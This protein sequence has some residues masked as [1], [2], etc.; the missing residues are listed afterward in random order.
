MKKR[1]L[2][3]LM[4]GPFFFALSVNGQNFVDV[5]KTSN[6]QTINLATDQVLQVNLPRKAATGY[7]WC[8]SNTSDDKIISRS[9]EQIGESDFNVEAASGTL[10][11]KVMLGQSGTQIIRYTGNSQGTTELTLELKRPWEKDNPAIDYFTITIVSSGKYTGTYTPPV[12][13][14]PDHV[15]ST[16][17]SVPSSWDWRSQCTS[18][19]NQGYCGDCWAYA[20]VGTLEANI[21]IIDGVTRDISEEFVTDCYTGQ[22]SDGC[23]GGWCAHEVWLASYYNANPQGGGAVY[24]ADDPTTCNSTGV[25]GTCGSSGYPTH[26]T[27]DSYADIPGEDS[28]GVPPDASMKEAIYNYGPIW[29]A[30]DASSSAFSNYSGGILT[31][32]NTS[33]NHAVILVGW[34]DAGGYWILRN[35]WGTSWGMS[36]Y[37]YISYGSDIVGA[38]A[39]YIVYKGGI[40]HAVPPVADFAATTT[41]SCTGIIQFNDAS[42]NNPT[43]WLWDFGDGTTSTSQ[44]PSHTY[45]SSGTYTV[46]LTAYNSYGDN[47]MTKTNYVTVNLTTAPVTTNAT[48]YGPGS[49]TLYA[50]GSGTLNW[51]DAA[52]GGNLINTGTSYVTPVLYTTTT[53]YVQSELSQPT[54]SVGLATNTATGGYYYGT[55]YDGQWGL[56]FDVL[57]PIR[58]LSVTVYANST[59]SR[60]IWLHNSSGT[61]INSV[62]VNIPNGQQSVT[63]NF[64]VPVGTGYILGTDGQN[65]LWRDQNTASYPYTISGLIS[66]TGNNSTAT[67]NY[68]YFYNWQ[69]EEPTCMSSMAPVIAIIDQITG[70]TEN[71][72]NNF[73]VFPNPNNGSFDIQLNNPDNAT[74]S[75]SNVL[76]EI[77]FEKNILNNAAMHIDATDLKKGIYYVKVQ[78]QRSNFIKKVLITN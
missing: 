22:G 6:G 65:N 11:G 73:E 28:Y 32:Y 56:I 47:T 74:V 53:Y 60:T 59:A 14:K 24:E 77:I 50:S 1:L 41:S 25:T 5:T 55:N 51:Y 30:V 23:N 63:L 19:K 61:V 67:N 26:E 4:I 27:I 34:D 20:S 21:K 13:V 2:F 46:V 58:I 7:I 64:D 35:S 52:T 66:I 37:M 69:V 36:G 78:T 29:V 45:T 49:V 68:Y 62:T 16:P 70:I 40:P 39:D 42:T 54:Q 72:G 76:G 38:Y 43:S 57:S 44:D 8:E 48:S 12:K 3:L 15:T 17:K 9:I 31:E 18:I 10:K 71:A 75:M 33:L